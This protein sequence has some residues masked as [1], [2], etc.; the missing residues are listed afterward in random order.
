MK[1]S[2]AEV[3]ARFHAK[4]EAQYEHG[5]AG[6]VHEPLAGATAQKVNVE[7][8]QSRSAGNTEMVTEL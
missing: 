3:R 6:N 2:K 5:D 4:S 8:L 7:I 1:E